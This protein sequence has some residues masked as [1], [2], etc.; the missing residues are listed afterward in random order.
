MFTRRHLSQHWTTKER[1]SKMAK[2]KNCYHI[3][4]RLMKIRSFWLKCVALSP[5]QYLP[6]VSLCPPLC[7]CPIQ[8]GL[9]AVSP[10]FIQWI[11]NTWRQSNTRCFHKTI[12]FFCFC[13]DLDVLSCHCGYSLLKLINSFTFYPG[14]KCCLGD[15]RGHDLQIQCSFTVRDV[16]PMASWLPA[17]LFL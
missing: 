7:L 15:S 11:C 9:Y 5:Q 12:I 1:N 8:Y 6:F 13:V 2:E 4:F 10:F 3:L 17:P 14:V 16:I